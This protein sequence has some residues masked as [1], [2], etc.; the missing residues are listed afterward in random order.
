V[1]ELA[2]ARLAELNRRRE[3]LRENHTIERERHDSF[4]V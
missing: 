3:E 1:R 4:G 2:D